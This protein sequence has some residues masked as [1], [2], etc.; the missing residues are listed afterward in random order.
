MMRRR[1]LCDPARTRALARWGALAAAVLLLPA[2]SASAQT[3][4]EPSTE[5]PGDP[6][7]P[8]PEAAAARRE[9]APP[10]SG[11]R[12][13]GGNPLVRQGVQEVDEL[14]YE[15]A[16]QTL[17]AALIRAG[18]TEAEE[19]AIYR[20]LAY[21]YF[22]LGRL[23]EAEGA[24]RRLLAVA[25]D[26]QRLDPALSPRVR[27]FFTGVASRWVGDGRPGSPPPAP[28]R[29]V[30]RSPPRSERDAD[31]D[32]TAVLEDPQ[33]RVSR[34]AL[35]YREGTREVFRRLDMRPREEGGFVA[36]VPGD[37]VRPPFVE[38]YVEALDD[39]GLPVAATGDVAAP[40][41]V[42]VPEPEPGLAQQWWFWVAVGAVAVAGG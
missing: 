39:S 10:G 31:L 15:Q 34:L 17:S 23:E 16:V 42:T 20:S 12:A 5:E 6:P 35:A 38:Y 21:A 2:S 3:P 11:G 18:N 4:A 36:T 37:D 24:F 19:R 13:S 9:T 1:H 33:G 8:D 22:A 32:L 26:A 30:H 27:A 14:R 7:A 41:R 25:P 29:I 28:V 40:L